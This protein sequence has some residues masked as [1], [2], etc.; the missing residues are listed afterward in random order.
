MRKERSL[1]ME[2]GRYVY[3]A[4]FIWVLFFAIHGIGPTP[5]FST[6]AFG[7]I[8][9]FLRAQK[10]NAPFV[11]PPLGPYRLL[12]LKREAQFHGLD[13]LSNLASVGK[14]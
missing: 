7:T 3:I 11:V 1:W 12:L 9:D 13:E 10:R 2:T 5:C 14:F 4:V 8:L 6:Q